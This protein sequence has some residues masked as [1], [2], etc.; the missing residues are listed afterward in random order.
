MAK[1]IDNINAFLSRGGERELNEREDAIL[2]AIINI[3]ILS[4]KPVGSRLLSKYLS[5]EVKLSP[6]TIRN[7]M[8]E[9]EEM[10]YISHPHTSA[11]R[12]PTDIGYRYYVDTLRRIEK[13]SETE[14]KTIRRQLNIDDSENVLRE[15]SRVLGMLSRNLSIVKI[16][17]I[18]EL[19][20]E[21]IELIRL[22]SDRLLVVVALD[23]NMV[24]TVTLEVD[25]DV[26]DKFL[27]EIKRTI[28]ER[29]AGR[30]LKFLRENFAEMMTE[31]HDGENP[32]VRL[33]I[34]SVEKIFEIGPVQNRILTHGTRNLLDYPEFEDIARIRG[35]IELIENEDIIVHLIDSSVPIEKSP[36]VLIG[37]ELKKDSMENYSLVLTSYEIGSA[38]GSIGL[39]G[40]KR[41]DYPRM[42]SL[43][44]YVS[45][46]LSQSE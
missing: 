39:I 3:Y 26:N 16:P 14:M 22:A 21:K 20:V 41:M 36:L 43:V 24:R 40:P 31:L 12:V 2:R 6:A 1:Y 38:T 35:V 5:P 33:F 13:L 17:Q 15:A 28:N 34:D 44:Q 32:L 19:I 29:I 7:V 45:D 9:L 18:A 4:A 46:A 8:A 30:P 42:I 37:N 11:G 10:G 25:F 23:S 27:E